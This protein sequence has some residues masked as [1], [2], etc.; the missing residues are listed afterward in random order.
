MGF[1]SGF[2]GLINAGQ[3]SKHS[4]LCRGMA[5]LVLAECQRS[6]KGHVTRWWVSG[7]L[8]ILELIATS[9]TGGRNYPLATLWPSLHCEYSCLFSSSVGRVACDLPEGAIVLQKH[10][11]D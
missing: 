6:S 8:A 11:T 9:N 4:L 5:N 3:G 2:N 7:H 1:N 10:G